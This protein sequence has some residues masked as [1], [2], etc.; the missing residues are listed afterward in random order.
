M[1]RHAACAA[2]LLALVA[3]P[4]NATAQQ[5][6]RLGD[7]PG[8]LVISADRLLPVASYTRQTIT[9]TQGATRR[10]TEDHGGS[11][12]FFGREPEPGAVHAIPRLAVDFAVTDRLTL[13][14]ALAFTVGFAGAHVDT[15]SAEGASPTRRETGGLRS[16]AL[17]F[18]PRA[19]YVVPI[20]ERFALWP[21]AGFAFYSATTTSA[22]GTT[23]P[24]S[25]TTITDTTFSLD[26]EAP[27]AWTPLPHA[28]VLVGPLANVPLAGAHATEF[29][30]T[31]SSKARS[32]DLSVL[33]LGLS[34]SLGLWLDL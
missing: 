29:S 6:R 25:R 24:G 17:G 28:F 19:G 3:A 9:S 12:A 7:R 11:I 30:Q 1:N 4:A 15:A 13:G 21:R 10:E 34:L 16:I 20:G 33:H 14:V 5:A 22:Q 26:L 8:Q 27:L 23:D 31:G 2:T 32:D 18:A